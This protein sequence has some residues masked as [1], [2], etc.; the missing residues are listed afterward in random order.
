MSGSAAVDRAS[1]RAR[2]TAPSWTAFNFP[3]VRS[4]TVGSVRKRG[5]GVCPVRPF[6]CQH[7]P[8]LLSIRR[9]G[10]LLCLKSANN[11]RL[12]RAPSRATRLPA[13][14]STPNQADVRRAVSARRRPSKSEPAGF[15]ERRGVLG[16]ALAFECSRRTFVRWPSRAGV[17][18]HA[19]VGVDDPMAGHDQRKAIRG[20]RAAHRSRGAG[21][22][23]EPGQLAVASAV[24]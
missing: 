13:P 12:I 20:H 10:R 14:E 16:G 19:A 15:C 1:G 9:Q 3:G 24:P 11:S 21:R 7:R 23:G 4:C 18:A 22:A 17:V 8:S 6:R 5:L 2:R